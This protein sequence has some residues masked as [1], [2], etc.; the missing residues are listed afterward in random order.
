MSIMICAY[1]RICIWHYAYLDFRVFDFLSVE[2]YAFKCLKF[3]KFLLSQ[4]LNN[5]KV[6]A[7]LC[8][9]C[10]SLC[11]DEFC[12][13]LVWWQGFL[14]MHSFQVCIQISSCSCKSC[15]LI[16]V[17]HSSCSSKSF[18]FFCKVSM[19]SWLQ[20]LCES[21]DVQCALCLLNQMLPNK[22]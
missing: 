9:R 22:I 7:F 2:G 4:T 15:E 18:E 19:N 6:C 17:V 16:W 14:S 13:S 3:F 5:K 21:F 10:H 20:V 12:W 1:V 11:N 8:V